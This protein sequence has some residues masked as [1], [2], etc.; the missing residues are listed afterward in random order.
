MD[1]SELAKTFGPTQWQKQRVLA[2]TF[3]NADIVE[4]R[5]YKA[6]RYLEWVPAGVLIMYP[7]DV[8]REVKLFVGYE[9][10]AMQRFKAALSLKG[11]GTIG[12][13]E[14][15]AQLDLEM[16]Y[17][18]EEVWTEQKTITTTETFEGGMVY[19]GW[20]LIETLEVHLE[21]KRGLKRH[22]SPYS[23]TKWSKS[24][25]AKAKISNKRFHYTDKYSA[26]A[27]DAGSAPVISSSF[28]SGSGD[29]ILIDDQSVLG[30]PQQLA[31]RFE[32]LKEAEKLKSLV[33]Q[34]N[35]EKE[36][37]VTRLPK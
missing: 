7:H 11:K 32:T 36:L 26:D 20:T 34:A 10:T 35:P 4:R 8:K 17:K 2:K 27:I 30:K 24:S 1:K 29:Y 18:T 22:K 5:N 28:L 9:K 25:K 23:T 13:V 3:G 31:N 6:W 15:E 19:A 37:F 21:N 16:E 14:A 12:V 33:N